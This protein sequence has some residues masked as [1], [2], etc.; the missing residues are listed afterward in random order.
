MNKVRNFFNFLIDHI[1]HKM[2]DT[3]TS[4]RKY[5]LI[6]MIFFAATLMCVLP[7]I[8]SII[9]K[10]ETLILLSG[11]QWVALMTTLVGFYYGANVVQ[12]K[13]IQSNGS[14]E[15]NIESKKD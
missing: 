10:I 4:S 13:I 9:F 11:T 5:K 14:V 1:K 12:K 15:V 8:F 3:K 6:L 7:P 2:S